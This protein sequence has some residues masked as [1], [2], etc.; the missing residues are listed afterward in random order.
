MQVVTGGYEMIC[1]V[2]H[3]QAFW[4]SL[5][6]TNSMCQYAGDVDVLNCITMADSDGALDTYMQGMETHM[7]MPKDQSHG[8]S[9]GGC[10]ISD[11]RDIRG[12][13]LH[14]EDF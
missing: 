8:T 6:K 1:L 2:V 14:I 4:K 3:D 10:E 7:E 12:N 9:I 13:S 11:Y 5:H